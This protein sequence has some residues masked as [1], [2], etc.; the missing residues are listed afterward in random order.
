MTIRQRDTSGL[1]HHIDAALRAAEADLSDAE[2]SGDN[3]AA[4]QARLKRDSLTSRMLAGEVYDVL[5]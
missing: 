4:A 1:L 3:A 5:F 2:W